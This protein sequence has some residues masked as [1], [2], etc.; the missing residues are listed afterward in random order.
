MGVPETVS[1][2]EM[3][4]CNIWAVVPVEIHIGRKLPA[5]LSTSTV[6]V[7]LLSEEQPDPVADYDSYWTI[8]WVIGKRLPSIPR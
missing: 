2:S 6:R 7:L 1:H 4:T 5:S 3:Q 8:A